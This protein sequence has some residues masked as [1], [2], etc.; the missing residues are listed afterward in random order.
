MIKEYIKHFVLCPIS[1]L[2]VTTHSF[3]NYPGLSSEVPPISA[4]EEQLLSYFRA[5]K[6]MEESSSPFRDGAA[7]QTPVVETA[8]VDAPTSAGGDSV[9]ILF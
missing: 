2:K 3:Q 1:E 9:L 8:P 7:T 6:D 5:A 4:L